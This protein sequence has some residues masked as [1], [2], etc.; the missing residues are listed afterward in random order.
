[1]KNELLLLVTLIA[2]YSAVV[3][4]NRIFGKSGL[5][6]WTIVATIAA[7]IEVLILVNAF[8]M[9]M[10][11]GN[12]L[13]ASTFLVTDILSENY[14]EKASLKAVKLGFAASIVFILV[15]WSW[16]AYTPSSGDMIHGS[17]SAVFSLTPRIMLASLSVYLVVQFFDV[18][19]YHRIWDIT[20]EK[21]GDGRGHLWIRNNGST[22]LSQFI[23]TVFFNIIAFAGVYDT[24][25]IVQIIISCY[26]IFIVT[27]LADTPFAYIARRFAEQNK[28][29]EEA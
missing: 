27:S 29:R 2:E 14:G 21:T 1:M 7:N 5:Y 10:T 18:W 26:I 20:K 23:N 4:L 16:L 9:E 15:S 28:N 17:I 13:F 8:G 22:L 25:T 11:L 12:I 24:G 19:I 3:L 6:L